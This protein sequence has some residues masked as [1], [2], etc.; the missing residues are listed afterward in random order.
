M[1]VENFRM[2]NSECG[3]EDETAVLAVVGE[4]RLIFFPAGGNGYIDMDDLLRVLDGFA[5]PVTYPGAD[6]APCGG[7]GNI[8]VD[9]ILNLLAAFSG[10][11]AC[12][13]PCP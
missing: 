11:Y 6:I 7:N 1:P 13:H 8:D 3:I 9:D 2:R 12:P 10:E 5:D 4:H